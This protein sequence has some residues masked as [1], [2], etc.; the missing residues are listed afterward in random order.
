MWRFNLLYGLLRLQCVALDGVGL[1]KIR[2]DRARQRYRQRRG[3]WTSFLT[4]FPCFL[5]IFI[6]FVQF[7]LRFGEK[8]ADKAVPNAR[9]ALKAMG[10]FSQFTQ[11]L[12]YVWILIVYLHWRVHLWR[13]I[14]QAQ[15]A[16]RHLKRL[17]RERFVLECSWLLLLLGICQLFLFLLISLKL[18]LLEL[19]HYGNYVMGAIQLL[20]MLL[21]SL[22]LFRHL[23]HTGMLQ[24]LNQLLK[25]LQLP[26]ELKLLRQ[27]LHV[28]P[29]LQRIQHLAAFYFSLVFCWLLLELSLKCG[30]YVSKLSSEKNLL[31][32]PRVQIEQYKTDRLSMP[33]AALEMAWPFSMLLL[34]LC[35]AKLQ[36]R[37]QTKLINNIWS[38]KLPSS[39]QEALPGKAR[40]KKDIISFLNMLA[41]MYDCF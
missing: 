34:L 19:L 14:D 26:N 32:Q 36:Q 41:N 5:L 20:F 24:S 22:Q 8:A 29:L 39:K 13:M 4:H 15:L 27:V 17:L 28:Y 31:L 38:I 35:A 12:A 18:V 37:E 11:N 33:F 30:A 40:P 16:T 1:L 23:L 25:Q 6:N 10:F 9:V 3:F 21:L 7:I 2:F